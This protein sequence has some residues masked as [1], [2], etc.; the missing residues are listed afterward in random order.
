[1]PSHEQIAKG[2]IGHIVLLSLNF[3]VLV[4]I[5][6]SFQLF[7]SDLPF[8]NRLVLAF[9]LMHSTALLSI[10]LA[11]QI[12]ELVRVRMPTLLISYYFQ[13]EDSKTIGIPLL[14]PT[15]SRLAVIILILVIS[16]GPILYLIFGVYGFLLVGSYLAANP[17]DPSTILS[18]FELFLNWMPPIFIF[19]IGI[20]IIS[21]VAIEFRHV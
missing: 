11:I 7:T 9:M 12:L 18:Y 20:V 8:L 17:F 13:I 15:K 10:Q 1:M 3:F 5:I 6:E 16:G 14:D 4:G 19:I 2:V 21:V